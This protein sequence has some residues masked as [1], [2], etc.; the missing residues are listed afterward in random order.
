MLY[1]LWGHSILSSDKWVS[2]Y[3]GVPSGYP[4]FKVYKSLNVTNAD[5]D[6]MSKN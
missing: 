6:Y 4:L 3:V 2:V 1:N 5:S